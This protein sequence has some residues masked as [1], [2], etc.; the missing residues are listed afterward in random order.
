MYPYCTTM[1]VANKVTP[2]KI[3]MGNREWIL[4]PGL[5]ENYGNIRKIKFI[6]NLEIHNE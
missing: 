5:R 1:L 2:G 3:Y 4:M 6:T